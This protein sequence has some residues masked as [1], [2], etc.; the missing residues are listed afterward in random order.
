MFER[1][2]PEIIPITWLDAPSS[3]PLYGNTHGAFRKRLETSKT[4]RRG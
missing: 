2:V 4:A 3:L 1:R